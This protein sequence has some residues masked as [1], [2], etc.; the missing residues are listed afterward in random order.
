MKT[1]A[2]YDSTTETITMTK[3]AWAQ[4]FPVDDLPKWL[5][6]YRL[7]QERFPAHA[8]NYETDVR[9]LEAVARSLSDR[10]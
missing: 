4:T 3:G 9:A 5:A 7:Q 8:D 6:F 10:S 1:T 2:T